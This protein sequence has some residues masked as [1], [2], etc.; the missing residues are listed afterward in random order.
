LL[1]HPFPSLAPR[2]K[3]DKFF[4]EFSMGEARQRQIT[5]RVKGVAVQCEKP[6]FASER[7]KNLLMPEV[8]QNT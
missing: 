8:G 6:I 3:S 5:A 4:Q 7:K 2:A 1:L